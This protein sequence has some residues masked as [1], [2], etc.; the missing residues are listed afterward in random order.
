MDQGGFA[1]FPAHHPN[2]DHRKTDD[3]IQFMVGL[4]D[5]V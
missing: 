2:R 1:N 4:G 5:L 3:K